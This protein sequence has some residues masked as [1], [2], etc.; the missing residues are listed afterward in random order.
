MPSKYKGDNAAVPLQNEELRR[1]QAELEASRARYFDLYD[2]APVGYTTVDEQ[3]RIKEM[4][5]RA[6]TLLAA[7][8]AALKGRNF[9]GMILA[10]DQDIY[11]LSRKRLLETGAL[12]VCELRLLRLNGPAFWAHLEI[13]LGQEES[14]R[15]V[16]IVIVD[17]DDQKLAEI[18]IQ[19]SERQMQRSLTEKET[20]LKEIHHRVKNNLQVIS[21]LLRMQ[22]QVLHDQAAS[23]SLRESQQRIQSIALIHER[24]YGEGQMDQIDFG[25]YTKTLVNELFQA[26]TGL[27][28]N[29]TI[30]LNVSPV[31]LSANQAVPCGLILNE[32]VTNAF[33]YAYPDGRKG[34]IS[35]DLHETAPGFVMLTVSDEGVGLKAGLDWKNTASMGLPIID[36]LTKQIGG[37][38]TVRPQPGASF[39]VEF[40]KEV[41]S[42]APAA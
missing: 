22:A 42:V 23:A 4:N 8:R 36:I 26:Y 39:T 37:K 6:S 14:A 40:Q 30:R 2:R 24:L 7:E 27:A 16:R 5:L 35:V 34:E 41:K 9:K 11:A 21:S 33:K 17:I 38:L 18:R 15:V 31:F 3:G 25:D 12:Q 1:V 20:M 28:S 29:V 10:E 19:E 13:C 32:L